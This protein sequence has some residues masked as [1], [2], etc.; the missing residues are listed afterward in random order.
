MNVADQM[1]AKNRQRRVGQTLWDWLRAII[2]R[3]EL[4][5]LVSTVAV[6]AFFAINAGNQGF[7][8]F[9]GTRNYLQVAANIGII[10]S[11]V[12]LLLVAGEFDLSVGTMVGAAGIAVAFPVV[13]FGWPLWAGLANGLFV[14]IIIG[15]VNGVLT[16]RLGI[17]SFLATLGM[18]FF[19]RGL[20]LAVTLMLTGTTQ[21]YQIKSALKG[22]FLLPV[23]A[24]TVKG[25]PVS[26]FW[27][28]G[29]VLV[30]AYF[31]SHTRF[32][33]WIYA[34]GGEREAAMKMGVPVEALKIGLYVATAAA[35][36][37]V[38]IVNM[39]FADLAEVGQGAG[40]EFEAIVAA[41]VGGAA[42]TGGLG[43]P[44]GTALGTLMFGMISQGFFYTNIND[45]WFYS[46]VGAVLVFAVVANKYARKVAM[47]PRRRP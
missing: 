47:R 28:L 13:H 25:L 8:T 5:A 16:V 27:W 19:L 32:G 43:S 22:D 45:N 38:A 26:I 29:V 20:T 44:I 11:P 35:A 30:C 10:A 21:I 14:A 34:S 3:P 31:L 15:C 6:F 33:N 1:F 12:T 7:L 18:M 2:L 24:G 37:I 40:K 23:F 17:P 4:T 41:V 42:T 36:V 46:F 39:L 9:T